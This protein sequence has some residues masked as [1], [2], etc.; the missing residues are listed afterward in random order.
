MTQPEKPKNP[1]PADLLDWLGLANAPRWMVSRPLGALISVLLALLLILA[2]AAAFAMLA[3]PLFTTQGPGGNLGTGGLIVALLG[4]PFLIWNTIIKQKALG[5]QKEGHL[6]DRISKAVEH[7]GAEK[8]VKSLN[9]A[10]E[11]FEE[12]KPNIEVRIGGILSLERIAQ[13]SCTYDKGRD[14]VRVMEILCAYVRENARAGDLAPT[15]LPFTKKSPRNDIQLA[16]NVIKRRSSDQITLEA[17]QLYRLDLHATD[18]DGCDLSAG[19]FSGALFHRS[20]LEAASFRDS[21]LSGTRMQYCLLNCTDFYS[22]KLLGTN[23]DHSKCL[24]SGAF[25]GD[26]TCGD[27]NGVSVVGADLSGIEH[28][29]EESKMMFGSKDTKLSMGDEETQEEL[30]ELKKQLRKARR[31]KDPEAKAALEERIEANGFGHWFEHNSSDL[32]LNWGRKK[33]YDRCG[34]AGWPHEG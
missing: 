9:A 6:T 11:P 7:L 16:M 17:S 22:A 4:A 13:D 31:D 12:T 24:N 14:H 23:M 15:P 2:L 30:I 3:S 18:L 28:L 8:S 25:G 10:G 20:R 34:I 27:V 26:L 33:F 19:N 5:F 32:A 21:N 1:A 29:G